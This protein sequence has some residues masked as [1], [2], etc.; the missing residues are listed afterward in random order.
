MQV[1]R[2]RTANYIVAFAIFVCFAG[3]YILLRTQDYLAVDGALRCVSVYWHPRPIVAENN[4]LLYYLNTY[5]WAKVLSAPGIAPASPVDYLREIHWMHALA[6]AGCLSMLWL[7]C[8]GATESF[9]ISLAAISIYAF[10]R[11]FLLHA[12]STSEPML[13]LFWSLASVSA[14]VSGL[15]ASSRLRLIAGGALLLLAMATYESMVL[16]GPAELLL[17]WK[18]HNDGL[19]EHH[20]FAAWFLIGCVFGWLATYPPAYALSGTTTPIAILHRFFHMGGGN[21]VFGG[22]TAAK[23]LNLVV[24]FST[25]IF[26]SLPREYQGIRW[27]LRTHIGDLQGLLTFGA[28]AV[29][30]AWLG[31]TI[32]RL[33]V[34][35]DSLTYKQRLILGCCAVA[36]AVDLLPIVFWDPTYDKLWMQ[37]LAVIVLAWSVIFSAWYKSSRPRLMLVPEALFVLAIC[38]TGFV[39]ALRARTSPTP[40]LTAADQLAEKMRP[41]DLLV[42]GW[43]PVWLLYSALWSNGAITFDVPTTAAGNGLKTAKLLD[44][45]I[46][47]TRASGGQV[48]FIGILDLPE[49]VW[50]DFLGNKTHLPYDSLDSIRKCARPVTTLTCSAGD[51]RLWSLPRDCATPALSN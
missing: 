16:I 38:S 8:L 9:A 26:P 40:C 37:P 35:S 6:A 20:T 2:L 4:H 33:I 28:L 48:Y 50:T 47:R 13:G 31:F 46:A 24:G 23:F 22:F 19:E 29:V 7:L 27:M 41:G 14:V 3:C 25:S 45:E 36:L 18:W 11:A 49:K 34:V 44:D 12:T 10:S 1:S 39:S 32:K 15:A 30:A 43:D 17:I 21:E 5:L 42:G 51:E